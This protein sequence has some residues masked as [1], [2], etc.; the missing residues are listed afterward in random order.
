M[1]EAAV[2]NACRLGARARTTRQVKDLRVV[3][4]SGLRANETGQAAQTTAAPAARK[5]RSPKAR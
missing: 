2:A 3:V 4:L 5:G 1:R